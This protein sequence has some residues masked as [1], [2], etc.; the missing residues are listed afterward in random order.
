MM[1]E[2]LVLAPFE[3]LVVAAEQSMFTAVGA[4]L[5]SRASRKIH[6]RSRRACWQFR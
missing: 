4:N 3:R 2:Q 5:P 6:R 1:C